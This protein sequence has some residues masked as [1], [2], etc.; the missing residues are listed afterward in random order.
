[1]ESWRLVWRQGFAP[2][3]PLDGLDALLTALRDDD[4]RLVQGSTTTPPPLR[5]VEDWLVEAADAIA[6]CGV[7]GAGGWGEAKVGEIE[8]FF[9]KACFDCDQ[10]AGEPAACRWV[11]NWYDDTPRDE[12]RAE[13][14]LE[15]EA[16]IWERADLSGRVPR[17]FE[18]A[19]FTTPADST[20]HGAIADFL[21][22]QGD[23]ENAKVWRYHMRKLEV[24]T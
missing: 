11:L 13:L 15:V 20:L 7:P 5:C 16:A 6:L 9:A 10:A 2:L 21:D 4:S 18:K 22:E 19:F 3:L 8:E 14:A 24:A 23:P 17:E 12:M 1:M